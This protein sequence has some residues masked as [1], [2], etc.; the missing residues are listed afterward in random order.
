MIII[1]IIMMMKMIS[2]HILLY[3]CSYYFLLFC[4]FRI[5]D[6]AVNA[7]VANNLV[8]IQKADD[9]FDSA[10]KMKTANGKDADAKLRKY[11][12]RII[13]MNEGLLQMY[14]NKVKKK[15]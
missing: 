4:L 1:I 5:R 2:N 14:M 7:V 12:K 8:T 15:N 6:N 13:S 3:I 9:L 10:K 11:Q